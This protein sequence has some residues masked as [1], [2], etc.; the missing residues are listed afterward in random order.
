MRVLKKWAAFLLTAAVLMSIF[1]VCAYAA[2][3]SEG[4]SAA[5]GSA[6]Q[7]DSVSGIK[8]ADDLVGKRIGVQFA[9]TGALFAKDVKDA[10]IQEFNKCI[11]AVMALIQDKVDCVIIDEQTAK[12]FTA[13]KPDELAVLDGRLKEEEYAAVVSKSDKELLASV[14]T[15]F[16]ELKKDGTLDQIIKSYIPENES[17]RGKYHYKQ[18]VTQGKT[19]RMATNAQFPPYEYYESSEIVGI[20][21][22]IGRAVADKLGMVLKVED[23]EFDSIIAAVKTGKADIGLSGFTV[24]EDRK[25]EINF[26]DSYAKSCQVMIVHTKSSAGSTAA[27]SSESLSDG[28]NDDSE[29]TFLD[30]IYINFIKD[31]RW[32]YLV[33][34]LYNTLFITFFAMLI[35]LALGFLLAIIRVAHDKN[36]SVPV[37]N[38]IAK[39]YVTVIRGT[40]VMVQLLIIYYV[41]FA[42]VDI[43]KILVAIIAFGLNSAAY[44]SEVVR[45]GIMS[46]DDGQF[47]AGKSLG[48][49]FP[50]T[51]I[52]VILPQAF[53]NILPALGNELISLLKETSISGYIGLID[54]TRGGDI[55]R[56]LTYEAFIPLI[57]VALIYLL[58]VVLLSAGVSRLERRLKKNE[59]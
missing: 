13:S 21:V 18:V 39:L 59:R 6:A 1:T 15:A 51:M 58:I 31:D 52:N 49:K 47:E 23:M 42:S 8:S 25:K 43:E 36:G 56:S 50:T 22:E 53:K 3:Q 48:L 14:N 24:S 37:L 12:A 45:S 46:I 55:I 4:S 35:G 9:T 28:G 54:L 27:S 16:S 57:A 44:V 10:S 41:I 32:R 29:P 20:D 30:R 26:S 11:D 38:F 19:L 17:D 7:V 2:E 34:G 5:E 33:S 40:P